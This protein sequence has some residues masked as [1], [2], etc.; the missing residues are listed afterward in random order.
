MFHDPG[1][2]QEFLASRYV[3][4]TVKLGYYCAGAASTLIAAWASSKIHIYHEAR[5][6]HRDELKEQILEPLRTILEKYEAPRFSIQY[7]VQQYNAGARADEAPQ[8]HGPLLTVDDPGLDAYEFLS[9]ALLEDARIHHYKNLLA[10]WEKIRD[11]W[12]VHID[13][14]RK[15]ILTT[16]RQIAAVT[17]LPPFPPSDN[18]S[19]YVMHLKL[20]VFC[21]ARIVQSST[22]AL[23]LDRF[24]RSQMLYDGETCVATGPFEVITTVPA[25]IDQ[26]IE[27]RRSDAS[28]IRDELAELQ[29]G[30]QS[31]SR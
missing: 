18:K 10:D 22:T 25:M 15:W 27:A 21:W 14:T 2:L 13:R 8:T 28:Q 30:S 17:G 5:N 31:L 12:T 29:S 7:G 11:S 23:T 9:A 6:S 4:W 16:A 1:P 24:H 3:A 26:I 20:A 19:P